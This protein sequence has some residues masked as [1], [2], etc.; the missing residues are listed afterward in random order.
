ML[1]LFM[2]GY[3]DKKEK[4]YMKS[5]K[6][7]KNIFHTLHDQRELVLIRQRKVCIVCV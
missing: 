4:S 2:F 5:Y 3:V 6:M 1:F 7:K